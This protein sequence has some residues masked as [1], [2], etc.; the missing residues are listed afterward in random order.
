MVHNLRLWQSHEIAIVFCPT[1]FCCAPITTWLKSSS[2]V[3]GTHNLG[4]ILDTE[5]VSSYQ[6]N[7]K[8]KCVN[9]SSLSHTYISRTATS[10][11]RPRLRCE[12]ILATT[13]P[14]F[15]LA[16]P[17]SSILPYLTSTTQTYTVLDHHLLSHRRWL[18]PHNIQDLC[19]W[20]GVR[21]NNVARRELWWQH[22]VLQ[23]ENFGGRD[24]DNAVADNARKRTWVRV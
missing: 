8:N 18:P 23:G 24:D 14:L 21:R 6:P 15:V 17:S 22:R 9:L 2:C 13:Q 19:F 7:N 1:L 4:Q 20:D 16:S 10:P 3:I 12:L 11:S 5:V